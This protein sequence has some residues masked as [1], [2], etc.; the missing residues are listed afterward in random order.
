MPKESLRLLSIIDGKESSGDEME[1]TNKTIK[2]LQQKQVEER[3]RNHQKNSVSH[4]IT[5]TR[6]QIFKE[7]ICTLF[8]LLNILIALALMLVNAWSNL[9]FL[10]VI[11]CN[12]VI[13]ILQEL[14]AKKLVDDLSL[15]MRNKVSVM[16][17]GAVCVMD[18]QELVIDDIMVLS[19][20]EQIICDAYL[21]QGEAEI[22]EALLSGESDPIH[23]RAG[24]QL[25]SGSSLISGKCYAQVIHVGEDNYANRI[26]NEVKEV[27]AVNSRLLNAM[28]RV[29]KLT[30]F[31]IIPLGILLFL[32]AWG[33]RGDS[34]QE[35]VITS[36]AGLLGML[37]KG[38]VLLISVSLAAGVSRLAK[39]KVLI[40]DLYSLETLA[41]VDTLCL[42]KTGTITTGDLKV[43]ALIPL[44]DKAE[45][46]MAFIQSFLHYSDDNNAT[47]QALCEYVGTRG[48]H[49]PQSR[50]P[51][52]SLR[53]WS[54]A[55]FP[56]YGTLVMG[57]PDK[58]LEHLDTSFSTI[59]EEGKRMIVIG[60]CSQSVNM[61]EPLPLITPLYAVV[62]T[63]TI[64]PNVEKTL[65]FF[66]KEGVEIKIIS[67]DH[68]TAVSAIAR[69]AGLHNW[70]ACIDMSS[71][72][73]DPQVI[74]QLADQYSVFGRVTPLQKKLLVQALQKNG[75]SVAMSG[76]GVNDMLALK[77]ADCSIAIAQGSDA[78]KQMSQIVLLDSDFSALPMILKEGRR[79]VNNAT[80]VAGV[81]F[82]K[83]IYSIL[84]SILCIVMNLPFP[85]IPIQITL[86]DLAIEAF[87]SF[88]TMLEPDHKKVNGDFLSTV[89]CNALPNAIAI[90]FSF[91]AIEYMSEGFSIRYDEAVTM[92]YL[93]VAVISMLAVYRS[94][95]PVNRL[96]A[97]I[98][99]CM[100]A[101]FILAVIL[102]QDLLHL[103]PLSY[104][105]YILTV[106]LALSA[107]LLRQ[108]LILLLPLI[109]GLRPQKEKARQHSLS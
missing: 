12:V 25:L 32:E 100:T 68:I 48:I 35:S 56:G 30:G 97:L 40:Q 109:P 34:I 15:L 23:K 67:G 49:E 91:L 41:N 63:D 82:I 42:D 101:G 19:S 89:L 38:L 26:A 22:N 37:P 6:R 7:N 54:S 90:V 105:L 5:K 62:F 71:I 76:D 72:G 78:V 80:R 104:R 99:F 51:F 84:L 33:I 83:T 59:M 28:K 75:H 8:N 16:R 108:I 106:I 29:T 3:I 103:T 69:Q 52:S 13:G 94:C 50:I 58:L 86:I 10:A 96:R 88:L 55:S 44:S 93:C 11:I 65:H 85:F 21:L 9:M 66:R 24:D 2:G 46:E 53:K 47:Y 87:P 77:E 39:H 60:K 70:S 14:H 43:E 95:R 92:M 107:I 74:N 57:A 79:V 98:C 45:Q 18:A 73:D 31:A 20:G 102:F 1:V 36:S 61:E 64:R 27:R 4:S 17:D 81:F